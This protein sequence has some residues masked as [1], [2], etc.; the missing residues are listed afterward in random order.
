M[1]ENIILH[2]ENDCSK[3]EL[4]ETVQRL[5]ENIDDLRNEMVSKD[6]VIANLTS[7]RD[8]IIQKA[9]EKEDKMNNNYDYTMRQYHSLKNFGIRNSNKVLLKKSSLQDLIEEKNNLRKDSHASFVIEYSP[10][11]N[12]DI[13]IESKN[14]RR[15]TSKNDDLIINNLLSNN[16][17]NGLIFNNNNNNN[18]DNF[19][20]GENKFNYDVLDTLPDENKEFINERIALEIKEIL[21][22]RI[23]F[24]LNSLVSENFSF[25][26]IVNKNNTNEIN[27]IK[28]KKINTS[29]LASNVDIILRNLQI[30]KEKLAYQKKMMTKN[31]E[32]IGIKLF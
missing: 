21:D 3:Q 12:K 6:R 15:Y 24:I 2:N 10:R 17:N 18:N 19:K 16:N 26:V 14:V 8:M 31:L 13:A 7:H 5:E 20:H 27:N 30:R 25:D 32:K 23:N 29:K 22:N 4:E 9:N 28:D 1:E 11:I